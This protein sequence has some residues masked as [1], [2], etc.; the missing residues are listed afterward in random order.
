MDS[1]AAGA[2]GLSLLGFGL[3]GPARAPG[4]SLGAARVTAV[5]LGAPAAI[6]GT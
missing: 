2:P 4:L 6:T 5:P 3:P 1:V